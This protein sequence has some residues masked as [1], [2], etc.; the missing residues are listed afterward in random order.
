[1]QSTKT[2]RLVAMLLTF[3]LFGSNAN[4]V[5]IETFTQP[6]RSVDVPAAEMGVLTSV[7]VEEGT[8]VRSGQLLAQI[9]D[10][11]LKSS[12]E[13]AEAAMRATSSRRAAEAEVALSEEQR[14]SY[15]ELLRDGN[16][17]QREVDRAETN[18]QQATARLQTVRE[19]LEM[20]EL[21][22]KRISVQLAHRR[23]E[24]PIDGVV[25]RIEKEAGE[26]VSPTD[27]IV[28]KVVQLDR[29]RAIFSVPVS[30]IGT[31]EK[32]QRTQVRVSGSDQPI[33]ATIE[34]ISPVVD[35]ESASVRVSVRIEN[36][37][38]R[39]LSGVICRWDLGADPT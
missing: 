4:A 3:G 24:S 20:R 16:A 17:T 34:T 2:V 38:G 35:A 31:L 36:P 30:L 6:Y 37:Q 8:P 14:Q 23:I 33:E 5:E 10:R 11:V 32:N 27:P 22:Y 12:L 25:V 15:R 7:L 21:E 9:D 26:F 1:M 18:Y 29:L 13:I 28:M 39:I 19:E